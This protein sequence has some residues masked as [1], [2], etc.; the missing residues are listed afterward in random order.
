MCANH[1]RNSVRRARATWEGYHAD[2]MRLC[3]FLAVI[4]GKTAAFVH[5]IT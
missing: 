3:K 5:V 1:R 2:N 4:N